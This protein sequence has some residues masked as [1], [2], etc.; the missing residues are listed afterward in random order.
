MSEIWWLLGKESGSSL[1]ANSAAGAN[2]GEKVTLA[3]IANNG[4]TA[5]TSSSASRGTT[6]PSS[7]SAETTPHHQEESPNHIVYR[8]VMAEFRTFIYH[9]PN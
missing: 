5:A 9:L 2:T 3:N 4:V 6:V 8:K 7:A 1:T